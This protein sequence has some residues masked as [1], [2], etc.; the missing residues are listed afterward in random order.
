M[1]EPKKPLHEAVASEV[2][3]EG[4]S[5]PH[6]IASKMPANRGHLVFAVECVNGAEGPESPA[7]PH[8]VGHEVAAPSLVGST[9]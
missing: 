5:C 7:R 2:V 3:L 6:A 8:S 4:D 1:A 9:G